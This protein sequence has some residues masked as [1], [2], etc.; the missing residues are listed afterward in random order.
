MPKIVDHDAYR[1]K[2]IER[3]FDDFAQRG[4][5]DVTMREIASKLGIS[6]GTLYHY[7]PTKKNILEHMLQLASRRDISG[8]M[9][10][11]NEDTPLEER[12]RI[13]SSYIME[14]EQWFADIVLLTIDYY[15]QQN[16]E[17]GFEIVNEADSHYGNGVAEAFGLSTELGFFFTIFFNG[18]VFHRLAFP[19]SIS[20]E[21]QAELFIKV[22]MAYAR[23][24][25]I[26]K[27]T[28]PEEADK[29]N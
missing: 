16:K 11:I 7:F 9:A 12:I 8:A 26:E 6:T 4:Y 10:P 21:E 28:H 5:S 27:N 22:M 1:D 25:G 3:Y 24:E 20:F 17:G 23:A 15:R 19:D 14:K 18:L 13:F 2:L 29:G